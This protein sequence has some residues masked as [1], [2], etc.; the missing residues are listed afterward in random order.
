MSNLTC[1][2]LHVQEVLAKTYTY[3]YSFLVQFKEC[4]SYANLFK[5]IRELR[6][7]I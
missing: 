3:S 2:L 5:Y 1:Q 4:N 7:L 6:V